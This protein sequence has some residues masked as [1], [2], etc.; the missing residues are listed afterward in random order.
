[1]VYFAVVAVKH[2]IIVAVCVVYVCAV[3]SS[4]MLLETAVQHFGI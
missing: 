4:L 3:K 1:M 2:K